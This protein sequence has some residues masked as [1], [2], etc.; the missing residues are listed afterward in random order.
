MGEGDCVKY[1]KAGWNRKEGRGNKNLKKGGQG[2]S[3]GGCLKKGGWNP[4]TNYDSV[5]KTNPWTY[6][7]KDLNRE[8]VTGSFYKK[9]AAVE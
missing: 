9:R 7:I 4:L 3:S 6:K 8:K 2:G 5:L 1:L